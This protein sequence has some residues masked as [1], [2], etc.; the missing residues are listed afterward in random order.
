MQRVALTNLSR[1]AARVPVRNISVSA[2][3]FV[4]TPETAKELP[5]G[6]VVPGS[7]LDPMLGDYPAMPMENLQ[8]RP[9]TKKWW[10][11]Q[12][13]RQYGEPVRGFNDQL[14]SAP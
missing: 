4:K 1:M 6:T 12:D 10:D 8:F 5:K 2:V 7:K 13:R 9:Y 11:T 3:R 14:T